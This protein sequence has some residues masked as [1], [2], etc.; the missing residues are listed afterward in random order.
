MKPSND[1]LRLV[2]F[3]REF[4]LRLRVAKAPGRR[5]F[6]LLDV[7]GFISAAVTNLLVVVAAAAFFDDIIVPS[8][9]F[10]VLPAD[11]GTSSSLDLLSHD[12]VE[13][14]DVSV[15]ESLSSSLAYLPPGY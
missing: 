11:A 2:A 9:L 7:D 3:G 12:V 13:V 6:C 5:G 10:P 14:V 15:S 4:L 8:F 1:D